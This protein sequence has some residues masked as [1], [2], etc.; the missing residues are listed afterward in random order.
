MNVMQKRVPGYTEENLTWALS[1]QLNYKQWFLSIIGTLEEIPMMRG[2]S[3]SVVPSFFV[4]CVEVLNSLD[5]F[6][7]GLKY[8]FALGETFQIL[9][10]LYLHAT[11]QGFNDPF[12]SWPHECHL[13]QNPDMWP[14]YCLGVASFSAAKEI[15][16]MKWRRRWK[17][18]QTVVYNWESLLLLKN[19][20]AEALLFIFPCKWIYSHCLL[21]RGIFLTAIER[22]LGCMCVIIIFYF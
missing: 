1:L 8:Y 11:E 6:K 12:Y 15:Q 7:F 13:D 2:L 14:Q 18:L 16:N 5:C 9:F 19:V 21:L 20:L 10:S 22:S 3:K 17:G 4:V